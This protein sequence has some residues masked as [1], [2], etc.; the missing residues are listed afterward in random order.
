MVTENWLQVITVL[1]G[2]GGALAGFVLRYSIKTAANTGEINTRLEG[3]AEHVEDCTD[4]RKEIWQK[5]HQ[6]EL[7]D[8]A[9]G[10]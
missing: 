10:I 5:I 3:F 6:L 9:E 2:I 7:K 8:A 4:D 1:M